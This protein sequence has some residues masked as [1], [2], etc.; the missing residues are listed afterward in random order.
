MS[1]GPRIHIRLHYPMHH[2]PSLL[3]EDD[4]LD[5]LDLSER[6]IRYR[7]EHGPE[8]KVGASVEGI[9][10]LARGETLPVR[11]K[12]VRVTRPEGS[13]RLGVLEVAAHLTELGIPRRV[14]LAERKALQQ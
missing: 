12:V 8:P 1:P 9:L 5:V 11:G 3:L 14:I 10:R 7:Q 13:A 4:E 6:G 2:G